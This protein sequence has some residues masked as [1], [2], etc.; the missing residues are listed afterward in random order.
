MLLSSKIVETGV[1]L[2]VTL[3]CHSLVK[4]VIFISSFLLG[5]WTC[6]VGTMLTCHLVYIAVIFQLMQSMMIVTT[7]LENQSMLDC[8]PVEVRNNII[9]MCVHKLVVD[10]TNT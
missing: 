7:V 9:I 3:D 1:L 6:V 8:M 5:Q 4:V 2:V 10:Y